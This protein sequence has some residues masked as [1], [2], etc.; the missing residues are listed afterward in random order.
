MERRHQLVML[1]LFA[2]NPF[3]DMKESN[4]LERLRISMFVED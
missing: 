2:L 4:M 1:L 3:C